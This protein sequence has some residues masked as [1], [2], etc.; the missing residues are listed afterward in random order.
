MLLQSKGE[1]EMYDVSLKRKWDEFSALENATEQGIL[2]GIQQGML[3]GMQQ[4]IQKGM[5]Q[6]IQQ[7]MQQG[8]KQ[9][10][11]ESAKNMLSL[12]LDLEIISKA[13]GLPV[14]EIKKLGH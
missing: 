1:K 12:G 2:Q 14:D 13:V 7:G 9:G 11:R 10:L 4:G 3:Q 8:I 5:Q 6:G